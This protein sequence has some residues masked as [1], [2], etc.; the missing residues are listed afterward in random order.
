MRIVI[1]MQ[2]A[3]TESRYRGIGRYVLGF[4]KGVARMRGEHDVVLV[5]NG[6]LSDSIEAIRAEF[7]GLLPQ[8]NIRVWHAIGPVEE[9]SDDNITRREIAELSWEAFLASLQPDVVHVGSLFEG[10]TGYGVS[11]IGQ[12]DRATPVSVTLHD[13]IP[14]VHAKR[15]LEPHPVTSR[16]YYR[17][18][19]YLQKAALL[20]AN[21]EFS[22]QEGVEYLDY[23]AERIIAVSSAIEDS[24]KPITVDAAE[25]DR[26]RRQFGINSSFLLYTG[27]ADERKNLP[28]LIEAY[29]LLPAEI[30]A[31]VQLV[32]VGKIPESV[33]AELYSCADQFGVKEVELKFT[34]FVSDEDLHALYAICDAFVFPSWHEGFG[35]PVLE[36]MACGAPVICANAGSLPEVMGWSD[37]MFDP[38][39]AHAIARKLSDVLQDPAFRQKLRE[40]G[41]AQAGKFSWDA[42]GRRAIA[43]WEKL[44]RPS[45]PSWIEQS[46]E[47]ERLIELV[48][49]KAARSAD[50]N[51]LVPLA[52][53]LAQNDRNGYVRQILVDVSEFC[54]NDAGTGVQRVVR[55]Y[56][57][58]LLRYPP[59]GYRVEPVYATMTH[60]YRYARR[61]TQKFLGGPV[62]ESIR[63]SDVQWQRGDIFFGLDMQHSVQIAQAAFYQKLRQQGVYVKFLVYDLLPIEFPQYF[64]DANL[65]ALHERLL[66]VMATTDGTICISRATSDALLAWIRD[67]NVATSPDFRSTW[68]H[69]GVD[70]PDVVEGALPPDAMKVIAAMQGRPSFLCVSTIEPRK[71][72]AQVLEAVEALWSAGQDVC[73][74]FVG[75]LGWKMDALADKMRKHREF[76]KRLF[77]LAGVDDNYLVSLYKAASGLIAASV[78][79]GFGL[80]LIEAAYYGLPVIARDIPVFREV[81]GEGA[82]YFGG[83]SAGELS[84]ALAAWLELYRLGQHP[85]PT[86]ISWL[87][88][89]D[90]TALLVSRLLE[91]VSNTRQLLVDISEL[92]QRDAKSGIQRVVR[93]ILRE[94]VMQPPP[95]YRVEPV[96]A[97]AD[98]P[99]RYARRYMARFL[100][101]EN[102]SLVDEPIEY[103][104][105]DVFLGLD[106]APA[107][108][109]HYAGFYQKLRDEGVRVKFVVYDLLP[110]R[111]N[112]FEQHV[113]DHFVRWLDVVAESDGALCIS[114]AVADEFDAWMAERHIAR[115]RPF[116]LNWFHLG[117]DIE[118]SVPTTGM[119]KSADSVLKALAARVSFLMVGTLEPRKGHTQVLDAFEQLWESG[120]DANLVIVGK[121]GWMMDNLAN[122][123]RSHAER[124]RRL[125]WLESI[126]DEFLEKVYGASGCLIAASTGEGFGLPLIEAAQHGVPILA[127]DLPVFREVAG[128][129][130]SYFAAEDAST[131]AGAIRKWLADR[132][133]G[134]IPLSAGMPF[135]SWRQ[136]AAMLIEKI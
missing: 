6:M 81:A 52:A 107:V 114:K 56:L 102:E 69:I 100:G 21:S 108:V 26:L 129:H 32:F 3:Q 55:N 127:R 134:T 133:A 120:V 31:K 92:V 126:S 106:L 109:P 66:A 40:H 57:D 45:R 46:R 79:E 116:A 94:W 49:A 131:L 65:K 41:L 130:A 59:A 117:S 14:L 44:N 11:S 68:A 93:S 83:D 62:D 71:N 2:G 121:Q 22:R 123:L 35:L 19:G 67:K 23:P 25:A 97:T 34:G 104:P 115:R 105:G 82:Y 135:L 84:A 76:G 111:A 50:R 103:S 99:Y 9:V 33:K 112:H 47:K 113:V 38:M 88:W 8:E 20:L 24:F 61:F 95:G 110:L 78:N 48:A 70:F 58:C 60:G 75:R 124:D 29:S 16:H 10:V 28:R 27:G 132:E 54:Q 51:M 98:E 42:V 17:K 89:K 87:N 74:T 86:G 12:F 15:Y 96:Y 90:S 43:E 1:D 39:D 122:R 91:G 30:R 63:D 64:F 53:C 125:F 13:L 18:I 73:L 5:V 7:D 101:T 80:S 136:S 36:A 119:P 85:K 37:A 118:N 72:Q 128:E 4:A 77:W